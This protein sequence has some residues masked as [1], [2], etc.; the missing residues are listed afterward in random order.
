VYLAGRARAGSNTHCGW[1]GKV[2]E[3][4]RSALPPGLELLESA[5]V[6]VLH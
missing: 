1:L 3:K 6:H 4:A 2:A 5:S